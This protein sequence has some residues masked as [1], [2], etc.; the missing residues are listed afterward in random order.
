MD[1]LLRIAGHAHSSL[2]LDVLAALTLLSVAPF[3]VV[4]STSFVRIVVVLSL[5]RSAIGASNLPPSTVLTGLARVL[6]F[7]IITPTFEA[8]Q[9]DALA[10]YAAGKLSQSAFLERA[11]GPLR[12]F[13]L[14]Q[15]KVRDVA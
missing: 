1:D 7:V 10:P 8:I 4:L 6:S 15:T 14:R 9:R 12:A 5:V 3:V 13:M 11:S 2:P